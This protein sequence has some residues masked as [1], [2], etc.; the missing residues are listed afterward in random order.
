M[1]LYRYDTNTW[2]D[3]EV[4]HIWQ[5]GIIGNRALLWVFYEIPGGIIHCS[6]GLHIL[7]S[8][9]TSTSPIGIEFQHN[10]FSFAINFFAEWDNRDD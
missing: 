1:K 9:F 2:D 8:L 4:S 10:R 5:F 7:L 3:G 6:G